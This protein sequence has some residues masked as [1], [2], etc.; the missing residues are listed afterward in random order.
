MRSKGPTTFSFATLSRR[1]QIA[2]ACMLSGVFLNA[3]AQ[4]LSATTNIAKSRP[5]PTHWLVSAGDLQKELETSN[6]TGRPFLIDVRSQGE[7]AACRIADAMNLTISTVKTKSHLKNRRIVLV[8]KAYDSTTL[9]DE[10]TRLE[11]G[12]FPHVRVL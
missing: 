12:G 4:P 7:F 3:A 6:A 5:L 10:S 1:A 9:L 2:I 8:D 11:K